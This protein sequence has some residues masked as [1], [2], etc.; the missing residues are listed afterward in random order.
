MTTCSHWETAKTFVNQIVDQLNI[1]PS[2]TRVAVSLFGNVDKT[3]VIFPLNRFNNKEQVKRAVSSVVYEPHQNTHTATGIN[4]VMR[5]V[6]VSSRGDR[7]TAQNVLIVL[8]DGMT[9][10]EG[11][12]AITAASNAKT[13]GV[14]V[15]VIGVGSD[16]KVS[17]IKAMSSNPQ[18]EYERYWVTSGFTNLGLSVANQV[19]TVTCSFSKCLNVIVIDV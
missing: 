12:S 15:L 6:F 16:I 13:T 2:H 17:E 5:E 14:T 18:K 19:V 8:T 10:E 11:A 9:T 7:P 1:G 4:L 3:R